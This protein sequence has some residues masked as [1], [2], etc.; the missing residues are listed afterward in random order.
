MGGFTAS[1]TSLLAIGILLDLTGDNYRVA[2]CALFVLQALG[3]A[4]ILR[5]RR[6]ALRR[7]SERLVAS[8]VE[9]VHVPA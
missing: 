1:M 5:L 6:A 2:F 9:T 8:R 7:E 3:T 4:Q